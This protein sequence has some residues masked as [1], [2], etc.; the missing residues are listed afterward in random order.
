[1]CIMR[2]LFFLLSIS[3]A[4]LMTVGQT[5]LASPLSAA[6]ATVIA[7]TMFLTP[8][9]DADGNEYYIVQPGD[10]LFSIANRLNVLIDTLE[11]LNPGIHRNDILKT[12]TRL[13]Y[14]KVT[15]AA[16]TPTLAFQPTVTPTPMPVTGTGS[17]CVQIFNDVNGDTSRQDTEVLV[18]G[19]QI[20]VALQDGTEVGSYTTDGLNEPHCFVDIPSGEYTISAAAPNG[21]NPTS[22]T[23]RR[24]TLT[25]GDKAYVSFSVQGKAIPTAEA[26]SGSGSNSSPVIGIAGFAL[27]VS[28][29]LML[30]AV[31]RPRPKYRHRL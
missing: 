14:G 10:T 3:L 17:I 12:G 7:P 15:P 20:S 26:T 9:A 30:Y 8:T 4:F 22:D 6:T 16:G 18:G 31:L 21:F 25:P 11:K 2:R 29:A 23:T 1:M 19:G 5:V 24:L 13:L 28:A 27:L